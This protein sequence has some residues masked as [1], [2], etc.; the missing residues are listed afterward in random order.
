[1]I[2]RTISIADDVWQTAVAS[3][4]ASQFIAESI[5]MREQAETAQ[6]AQSLL[7]AMEPDDLAFWER[8]AATSADRPGSDSNKAAQ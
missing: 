6:A 3:G 7:A 5:R 8:E 4:N 2:R 1:M